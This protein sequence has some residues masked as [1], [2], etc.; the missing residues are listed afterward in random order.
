M[1]LGE[2][3]TVASLRLPL[4]A[5]VFNNSCLGMVKLEMLVEGMPDFGVDLP[6]IDYAA[7]ARAI[8]FHARR[9]ADPA[10]L[11]D[12]YRDALSHD[13]RSWSRSS[14]IPGALGTGSTPGRMPEVGPA[15]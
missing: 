9:V 3:I 1:L 13:G 15:V 10:D 6:D 14:P 12:A 4:T 2:L 8:G 5:V 7:I 11:G